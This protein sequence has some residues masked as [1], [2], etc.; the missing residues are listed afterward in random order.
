[1]YRYFSRISHGGVHAF[2]DALRTQ[3]RIYAFV[4]LYVASACAA[5]DENRSRAAT[6]T[7]FL[8]VLPGGDTLRVSLRPCNGGGTVIVA[9]RSGPGGVLSARRYL[10]FP[11]T[12]AECAD[13]T[14]DGIPELLLGVIKETRFDRRARLRLFVYAVHGGAVRPLWLGS[15]L[16]MPLRDFTVLHRNGWTVIATIERERSG[17]CAVGLWRWHVFGPRFV[18]YASRSLTVAAARRRLHTMNAQEFP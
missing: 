18:A 3:T 10:S 16:G 6:G 11:V 14:G 17:R 2:R 1:M 7:S 13:I 5:P 12:R 9:R 15:R 4:L 8:S